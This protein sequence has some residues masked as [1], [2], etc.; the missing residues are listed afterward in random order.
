MGVVRIDLLRQLCSIQA[1]SGDEGLLRDF[2]LEYVKTESRHWKVKPVIHKGAGFQD[3]VILAFGKPRTAIFAHLD[4]IGFTVRYNNELVRIGSPATTKGIRLTG[5]DSKGDITGTLVAGEGGTLKLKAERVADPGTRL[6][7]VPDFRIKR[8]TVQCA[9][10]DNRLGVYAALEVARTLEDGLIIFTCWEEHGGGTAGYL[11]EFMI[12]KYKVY[13]ALISDITWVTEGVK[14]GK[15]VVVSLRD[16][17]IPRRRYIDR[18]LEIAAR[19]GVSY[20][21]E[22]ESSGGSDGTELQKS[23]FPIDWCFIGAPEKHVHSPD[24]EVHKADITSMI[25]LYQVLMKEL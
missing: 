21:V 6:S 16:S 8:N 23:P 24:E 17:G 19:S 15:G 3:C 13:Q 9:Y 5:T 12:R 25:S 1:T 20:Q 22:V 14:A 2:I 18:I 10:M 11:A 7:F 4:N